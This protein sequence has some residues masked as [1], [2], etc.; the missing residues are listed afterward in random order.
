MNA[1]FQKANE[2]IEFYKRQLELLD[3][4]TRENL[5][6]AE[7]KNEEHRLSL[8]EKPNTSS[9]DLDEAASLWFQCETLKTQ[10]AQINARLNKAN[11][12][13]AFYKRQ[14]EHLDTSTQENLAVAEKKKEEQSSGRAHV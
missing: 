5:A 2:D 9:G 12:D 3:T 1:R 11:E 7:K 8:L 4:S 10:Y 6:A 13:I 14:L